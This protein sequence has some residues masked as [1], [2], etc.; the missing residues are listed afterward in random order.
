MKTFQEFLLI[1]EKYYAPDEK[2]PSGKTP[3]EKAE[4]RDERPYSSKTKKILQ[5]M[6]T[7]KFVRHGADNPELNRHSSTQSDVSGG[8]GWM[9]VGDK[10]T[11]IYYNV[12][13]HG[14][15]KDG[16]RV[17]NV[18]W[19]HSDRPSELEKDPERRTELVRAAKDV[20]KQDVEHRLPHG[21]IVTNRPTEN[22]RYDDQKG[23]T[24]KNTRS[25]LYQRAGFGE[26]NP[27]TGK[28]FAQVGRQLN[29]KQKRKGKGRLTPLPSDIEYE[30]TNH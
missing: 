9:S 2:L 5:Q 17:F 15:T 12:S 11:G 18:T 3:E 21:S 24:K 7:R 14:R 28:Q 13:H 26:M 4:D 25:R 30:F 29:T 6:R 27:E 19:N 20:W 8:P 1:A 16:K 10:E 22:N 23:E